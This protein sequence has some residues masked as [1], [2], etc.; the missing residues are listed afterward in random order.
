MESGYGRDPPRLVLGEQAS[1]RIAGR[2]RSEF[3]LAKVT[4]IF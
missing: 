2:A 4:L 3:C 1:P